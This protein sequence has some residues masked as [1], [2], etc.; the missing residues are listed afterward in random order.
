MSKHIFS[1]LEEYNPDPVPSY[2]ESVS[3]SSRHASATQPRPAR[4]KPQSSVASS[5]PSMI[6]QERT[7]RIQNMIDSDILPC[8]SSYLANA[9][10]NLTIMIIPSSSLPN[11][12]SELSVANVVAPSFQSLATVGAVIYLFGEDNRAN[13]WTQPSVVRELDI[14]LHRELTG[15]VPQQ[16]PLAERHEPRSQSQYRLTPKATPTLP[17][18]PEKKSWFKRALPQLPGPEHDPTGETGKWELGWRSSQPDAKE[19]STN[20]ALRPDEVA[21][22]IKLQDISFRTESELGLLETTTVKCIW[23]NIEVGI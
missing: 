9:V 21:V 15:I 7:R 14:L 12:S 1:E 17:E 10:N 8:F 3:S 4:E 6:R 22:H 18:R 13:F 20:R 11:T 19:S 16:D 2:E 5:V 23:V